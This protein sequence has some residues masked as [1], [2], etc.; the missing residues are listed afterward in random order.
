MTKNYFDFFKRHL[1][2]LSF[3]VFL[4]SFSCVAAVAQSQV[5]LRPL[6]DAYVRN[7]SYANINYGK[8]TAF[9]VK[10]STS[11]GYTKI[12]YLKFSLDSLSNISSAKIRIYGRN[13]DNTS[14]INISVFGADSDTWTEGGITWNNAPTA[15]T[16]VLSSAGVNDQ[17]AYYEFDVTSYAKAQ[18]AGDKV[19][20]FLIKD[21]A[22]QNKTLTFNSRENLQNPPQLVV[23]SAANNYDTIPPVVK[24]LFNDAQ[25]SS[26]TYNSQVKIT[27][28]SSDAGGSGL[29]STQYSING[30]LY[31]IYNS[32]F[33][34][35]SVGNYTIKAKAT[36]GNGN[37]TVTND[38]TF[39]IA[40]AAASSKTLFPLADAFVRNGSYGA[41]N[42]GSD[43]SL[44]VKGSTS[45][46]YARTSYVKFALDSVTSVGSA[47][48]RMYGRNADN[49]I[50]TDISAFGADNDSW[51][52]NG[53][54]F[55]N[56]PAASTPALTAA[57]VTDQAKY[58]DFDVTDYV[59]AQLA[60]DKVVSFLI[61]DIANQNRNIVFNS[62]ENKLNPPQLVIGASTNVVTQSNALLFVE[63]PDRFPSNDYFV[64][65]RVEVPWSRDTVT[66][67]ANHD[68]IAV[69]IHNKGINTLVIKGL[70]LSNDS[71]WKIE[72]L[73][74]VP[75]VPGSGFPLSIT[76]GTYADVVIRFT[77]ADQGTRVKILHDTLTIFSN[78]DK[79]PA[80]NVF[81]NG[82]WQKYGEGSNEPYA[83]EII[84]AFGFKTNTGFGHTDPDKGD[85]SKLK[86]DEIKPSY[87]TIAD[88]SR[89][90]SIRQISSYHG[91][92]TQAEAISWFAKGS[93]TLHPV[94]THLAKDAQSVLPRKNGSSTSPAEGTFTT[95]GSFGFK[96]GSKDYSD[97]AKNPSGKIGLRV[98][99]A[100]DAKGNVMPNCYLVSNDYLGSTFTNYD[101][102]DNTYFIKNIRPATGSAFYSAL[103]ANPSA[104]DFGEK[105]LQ[106]ANSLTL[107]LASLGKMYTD[108]S[109]DPSIVISSVSIVGENKSEFSASMP[110]KT[111][112]NPQEN[113]TLTVGF[114]PVSQGLKIADLLVYYNNAQAPLRVPL[115]GIAKASGVTVTA[116]YRINSGSAT[117][118]TINGKTWSADNQYA[119]DNLEP[120][121]NPQVHQIAATDEDSLY[122]KEQSSNGDKK[123][124]RYELPVAN[125]DYVVRLHFAELYWGAPGSGINGGAGSR[126]MDVSL[127]NQLR[128][129]NFD[130][131]QEVGG[132][133]ALVK[134]I[135]VTVTDGKLNIDFSSTVNRPMVV[136]V[137]VYSFRASAAARPALISS[138]NAAGFDNNLKKVSVYPN[139][140]DKI[141]HIQF[142]G[143]YSGNSVLQMADVTGRI[144]NIGKINLQGG[145]SNTVE[146]NIS[147]LSLKPGFYYLRI[148]SEARPSEAIKLI[149]R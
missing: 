119:F 141:L 19:A 55:N 102:N 69:R 6:A 129:I 107:N 112:L 30:S 14:S 113:T 18:A 105:T 31:K 29:A 117:P 24:I 76:S 114:N 98:W 148:L 77:A 44:L 135:P 25:G 49:T 59:K 86:G 137:E 68:S 124:F 33:I 133:A 89:P 34:I 94:F 91:C 58:Y 70:A 79:L 99:K 65:S 53:I 13:T 110:V 36:D 45:T 4:V 84:N 106:T 127:E 35:D 88:T 63:N 46:G 109:K 16:A 21:P 97:A 10:G 17:G 1:L 3:S 92:C 2:K 15:S 39:S 22:N 87:F 138:V 121:S 116:N 83:K 12:S 125:G 126:V 100:L 130:V 75:Y 11:S 120:Y 37:T 149:V 56:A 147:D 73:K 80:K 104:L 143:K 8:D 108:S 26:N 27:I 20:S 123:P 90:I 96:V 136:A 66:Y 7:G 103:T 134:N 85:S 118:V 144:Y 74:G 57:G 72:K 132:A 38:I 52:E 95:T 48:L 32:S 28:N 139:P 62:K 145:I 5:A 41:T 101:Y 146:I 122:F 51:T 43:T 111:T 82:V 81:L 128:L 60:G 71:A 50:N 47:K 9:A 40:M 93:A 67:N 140:V 64:F 42:Y 131:T 23:T 54:T 78:D 115:Y 61:K 142:P